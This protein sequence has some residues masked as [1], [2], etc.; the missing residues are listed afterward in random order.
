M[1]DKETSVCTINSLGTDVIDSNVVPSILA[2]SLEI[3]KPE[4][5]FYLDAN[6]YYQGTRLERGIFCDLYIAKRNGSEFKI[7]NLEQQPPFWIF[8]VYFTNVNYKTIFLFYI[9][10]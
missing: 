4:E 5:M 9:F 3:K 2:S 10:N 8:E 7:P 1:I 6:Y